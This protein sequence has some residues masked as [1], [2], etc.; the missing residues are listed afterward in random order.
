M[1]SIDVDA[2]TTKIQAAHTGLSSVEANAT[3]TTSAEVEEVC[4]ACEG[5]LSLDESINFDEDGEIHYFG[6]TS[7]RLSFQTCKSFS[8]PENML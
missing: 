7:G 3:N 1:Y 2:E 6:A 4:A 8:E 5:T